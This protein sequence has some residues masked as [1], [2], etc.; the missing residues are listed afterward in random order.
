MMPAAYFKTIS[1]KR[2]RL[3]GEGGG[4]REIT[5]NVAILTPDK[6]R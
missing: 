6:P 2:Q 3:K 4:G 1:A 5:A